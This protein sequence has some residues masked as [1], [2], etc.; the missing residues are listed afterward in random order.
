[1]K[2]DYSIKSRSTLWLLRHLI[3]CN[4]HPSFRQDVSDDLEQVC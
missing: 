3:N 2:T 4:G 1:M